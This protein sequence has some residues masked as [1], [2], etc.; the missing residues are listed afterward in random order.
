MTTIYEMLEESL[1]SLNRAFFDTLEGNFYVKSA[2]GSIMFANYAQL[3]SS[4]YSSLNSVLGKTVY[5][6][7]Q[8]SC[9]ADHIWNNDLQVLQ[10]QESQ[11]FLE[12]IVSAQQELKRVVSHKKP[13]Y[14]HGQLLGTWGLSLEIP[15]K[16]SSESRVFSNRMQVLDIKRK[17]FVTL[18]LPLRKT[19]YWFLQ[20]HSAKEVAAELDLSLRT[21]Q[22]HSE[23]I[24]QNC[25]Y[26]SLRHILLYIRLV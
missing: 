18:S 15:I 9:C 22:H 19:L 14:H 2:N 6:F 12:Y 5:D 25:D 4:G 11:V 26:P 21:I 16:L 23:Y 17:R 1:G 20:G 7:P 13:F 8:L 3:R 24:K 10:S